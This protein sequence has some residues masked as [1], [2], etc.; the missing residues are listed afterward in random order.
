[1][2]M[3]Q[4]LPRLCHRSASLGQHDGSS[5]G[6]GQVFE[7]GPFHRSAQVAHSQ[8]DSWDPGQSGTQVACPPPRH[9]LWP[10]AKVYRQ[11]VGW[12]LQAPGHL[13]QFNTAFILSLMDSLKAWTKTWRLVYNSSAPMNPPPGPKIRPGLNMPITLS[14]PQLGITPFQTIYGYQPSVFFSQERE[15]MVPSA[16]ALVWHT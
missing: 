9:I 12:V 10:W 7:N 1:M 5:D 11:V 6:G 4:Y 16:H 3:I 14:L 15:V 8:G 13:C 2:T